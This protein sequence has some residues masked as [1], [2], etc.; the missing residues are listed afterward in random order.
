MVGLTDE[1][2]KWRFHVRSSAA[3]MRSAKVMANAFN[4]GFQRSTQR[5]C[6]VP[7]VSRDLVTR[8]NVFTADCSFGITWLHSQGA[9]TPQC[10]IG[11]VTM[12][13]FNVAKLGHLM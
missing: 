4:A 5:V 9:S 1:R 10:G 12:R 11:A 13:P 3:G 6:P 7:L 2:C 8:Y